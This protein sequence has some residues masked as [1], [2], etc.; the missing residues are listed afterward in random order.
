MEKLSWRRAWQPTPVVLPRESHGQRRLVDYSPW[1]CNKSDM[2]E[3]LTL[4]QVCVV[5]FFFVF[6]FFGGG[7]LYGLNTSKK[8]R[9]DV[10]AAAADKSLQSCPTL[11]DPT[12]GSQLGSSVA[13]TL[14]A[15]ILEWVAISFST[16]LC[17]IHCKL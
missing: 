17:A 16:I 4:H 8:Y 6:V 14:Q 12:N 5:L 15:R 1:D 9:K 7:Y 2:T 3:Q 10:A 11:C 13:G